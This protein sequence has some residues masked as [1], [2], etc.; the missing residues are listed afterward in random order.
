MA[1]V[2]ITTS[3]GTN[4]CGQCVFFGGKR[5]VQGSYLIYDQNEPGSCNKRS[6]TGPYAGKAVK[7]NQTCSSF[8][9][10]KF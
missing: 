4:Y 10:W 7:G 3:S 2:R 9:R 6:G 1:E 5:K 8:D